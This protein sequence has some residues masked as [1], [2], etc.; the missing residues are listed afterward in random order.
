MR[1]NDNIDSGIHAFK[2]GEFDEAVHDLENATLDDPSN[3]RAF[4]YLGA[5]YV[6]SGR[7]NAAI[8]AFKRASEI[9]PDAAKVHYNLGQAYEAADVPREAWF[10]YK[11]ALQCD[12]YYQP[13]RTALILLGARLTAQRQQQAEAA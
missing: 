9:R 12:P 11:N 6:E 3:F 8:G 1:F 10:E 7:Y 4:T 5:A 2:A 13:A